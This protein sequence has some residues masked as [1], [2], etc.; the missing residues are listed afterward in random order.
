MTFVSYFRGFGRALSTSLRAALQ[1][2]CSAK[3]TLCKRNIEES[4]RVAHLPFCLPFCGIAFNSNTPWAERSS[5]LIQMDVEMDY[6]GSFAC[7][8]ILPENIFWGRANVYL[9][10]HTENFD[11]LENSK[12]PLVLRVAGLE[13]SAEPAGLWSERGTGCTVQ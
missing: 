11:V 8:C 4:K 7:I 6:S 13:A 5:C 3:F 1:N 2:V 10:F 9:T 12:D